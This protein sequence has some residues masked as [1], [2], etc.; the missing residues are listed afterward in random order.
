MTTVLPAV[1]AALCYPLAAGLCLF[2]LARFL[3]PTPARVNAV[4]SQYRRPPKLRKLIVAWFLIM[5][6]VF[7]AV[8]VI[9]VPILFSTLDR[10]AGQQAGSWKSVVG[11]IGFCGLIATELVIAANWLIYIGY[12]WLGASRYQLPVPQPGNSR[13]VPVA[14]VI[15]CCDEDPRILE[16]SLSSC[17]RLNYPDFEVFL[18][19]NSRRPDA[20]AAAIDLAK[21]C[22]AT[23]I[24]LP[25]RGH[26]QGAMN[27]GVPFIDRRYEYWAVL[28][29]D[30]RVR[31]NFLGELVP[32][33]SGDERVA[34]VQTP[35]FYENSDE[36]WLTRAAAQQEMLSYDTVMEGKGA[37][38]RAMCCGTN[39]VI[40]RSAIESVGGYDETSLSEDMIMSY[41]L[42]CAG[43][44][45]LFVRRAYAF[46]I[47]PR[48]LSAYWKQQRRWVIGNTTIAKEIVLSAFSARRKQIPLSVGIEYLWSSGYYIATLLLAALATVPMLMLTYHLLRFG[49]DATFPVGG[50]SEWLYLSV[51]PF[52]AVVMAFPYLHMRLRGYRLRHLLMVQGILA[53]TMPVYATGVLRALRKRDMKWDVSPKARGARINL[54]TSPQTYVF[55]AAL[56]VGSVLA[57]RLGERPQA[58]LGWVALFWLFFYTISFGHFFFYA[59]NPRADAALETDLPEDTTA[60]DHSYA[61]AEGTASAS[62]R[63]AIPE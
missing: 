62:R 20:K 23:I 46:G 37:L 41:R 5:V 2:A 24:D 36:S 15:A 60:V 26:K 11:V 38:E 9:R 49:I 3:Y 34:F 10:I 17:A 25:N 44:K 28:D 7:I 29:A 35:Q 1:L 4:F 58:P 52:Y 61:E 31:R 43:W 12:A 57:F 14:V 55:L 50:G 42:H 32:L 33:L 63:E 22:G 54:L 6:G 19:E 59:A 30:Q 47:G 18:L 8:Q 53:V 48:D 56:A 40:R 51:L 39:Y 45:S 21:R 27:D 13:V 16:R